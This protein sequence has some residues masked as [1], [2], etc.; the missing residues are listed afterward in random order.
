[1]KNILVILSLL[2]AAEAQAQSSAQNLSMMAMTKACKGCDLSNSQL[3]G[4]DFSGKDLT[5]ANFSGSVADTANFSGAKL[6]QVLLDGGSFKAANFDGARIRV[7]Y[8]HRVPNGNCAAC[9]SGVFQSGVDFRSANFKNSSVDITVYESVFDGTNFSEAKSVSINGDLCSSFFD[10][11]LHMWRGKSS[12]YRNAS[13]SMVRSP[14]YPKNALCSYGGN[15]ANATFNGADFS[16]GGITDGIKI[17]DGDL[18]DASFQN[19]KLYGAVFI[20]SDLSGANFTNADLRDANFDG[21]NLTSV[22]FTGADLDGANLGGAIL[23]EAI[24][25]M[26]TMLFFGCD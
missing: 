25:T 13:F 4:V 21:A 24:D 8:T 12:S 7:T 5:E 14:S 15:F 10:M 16:G 23:C 11:K 19:A 20:D 9:N 22:N 3:V 6:D 18:T 26:G 2:I 17:V 1:M